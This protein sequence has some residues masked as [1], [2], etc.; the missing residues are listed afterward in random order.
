MVI[1][2]TV[3]FPHFGQRVVRSM[4]SSD[5][6][7]DQKTGTL[8]PP[9]CYTEF[10]RRARLVEIMGSIE[11]ATARSAASP[12]SFF[13]VKPVFAREP[14]RQVMNFRMWMDRFST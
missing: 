13:H 14:G 9:A 5:F 7:S 11:R 4:A 2:A 3:R 10:R 12:L 1:T 6:T 8:V